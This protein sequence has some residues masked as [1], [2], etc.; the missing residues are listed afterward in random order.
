MNEMWSDMGKAYTTIEEEEAQVM[1]KVWVGC[2]E[3]KEVDNLLY[4]TFMPIHI[5]FLFISFI[6]HINATRILIHSIILLL[7]LF[8]CVIDVPVLGFTI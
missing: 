3:Y 8:V 5:L 7:D 1:L 6:F 4:Y 2:D